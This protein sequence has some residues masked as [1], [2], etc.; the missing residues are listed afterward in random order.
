M[1]RIDQSAHTADYKAVL[2]GYSD[3][4]RLRLVSG[5]TFYESD[6]RDGAQTV[7]LVD[8]NLA[9]RMWPE[10]DPLG[11][12]VMYEN[13]D[14]ESM[15]QIREGAQVVG[16]VGN[17]RSGSL[18]A[19]G[20]ETLYLPYRA[21]P[22]LPMTFTVKTTS[23]PMSVV[24][25]V[26]R[27]IQAMDP[28]IPVAQI[29]MMD[30]YVLEAMAQTRFALIL[31]S[32]FASIALVLASVGLYG[33]ISYAVGQRT[34]E[35]GVRIAFGAEGGSVVRLILRQG[36]VLG[37]AGVALGLAAALMLTQVV[38]SFLVGVT[39]TDPI[40]FAGISVLLI[41]VTAVASYLPARKALGVDPV[42]ALKGE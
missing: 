27:E 23:D 11:K 33:V 41:S 25:L 16:V 30:D 36:M 19:D 42:E 35:I 4:M 22:W 1:R 13:F 32:V 24:S 28:D 26:R 34:Q 8:E 38:S 18:A 3:L 29:R 12:Q 39:A 10:G 6:N 2:P 15:S 17:V 37:L 40:T 31:L 14:I 21:F 9:K 5:R 7:A 20:R